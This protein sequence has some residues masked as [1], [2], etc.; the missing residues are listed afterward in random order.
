MVNLDPLGS[1]RP[2]NKITQCMEI[3]SVP[4]FAGMFSIC[5]SIFILG[6]FQRKILCFGILKPSFPKG[7]LYFQT[8]QTPS[9]TYP[10]PVGN[11]NRLEF[12]TQLAFQQAAASESL[13]TEQERLEMKGW[14]SA[15]RQYKS[16]TMYLTQEGDVFLITTTLQVNP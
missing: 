4:V 11:Q 16:T 8:N 7:F 9:L 6:R 5:F 13:F 1:H 14:R 10:E 3:W 12:R 2:F 15:G